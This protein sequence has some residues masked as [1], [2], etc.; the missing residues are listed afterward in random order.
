MY[1]LT[2]KSTETENLGWL[3]EPKETH[4][5]NLT[6]QRSADD[7]WLPQDEKSPKQVR[8]IV[9]VKNGELEKI[10]DIC[11]LELADS[12][13]YFHN[14]GQI[15]RVAFDPLLG[16]TYITR[17]TRAAITR[18]LDRR[19]SWRR[20]NKSPDSPAQEVVIDPPTKH[21]G[22]LHETESYPHLPHVI[23]I[24]RQ[25]FFRADNTLM[26]VTGYDAQT[27]YFG[28]YNKAEFSVPEKPS[29]QDALAA[30]SIIT[31]LLDEFAFA[32]PCDKVAAIA[33]IL[34]AATRISISTAPMVHVSA[35]QI[36]TGKSYLTSIIS[37]F[38]SD[39]NP[40]AIAFPTSDEECQKLL[41]A[42]LMRSPPTII[43]DNLTSD[44]L[45][46]KSL[47][48][49][50]TEESLTGRILGSS[51]VASVST[52]TL[53]L[54]SGNNVG[55]VKDMSRRCLTIKLDPKVEIPAT[56]NFANNPLELIR[57]NRG[58]YA[59]LALTIVRAWFVNDC[60]IT[61]CKPL[62]SYGEWTK[63][64]RQPLLWLGL[65]DPAERIFTQLTEDPD[66]EQLGRLLLA[67]QRV[68]MDSHTSI[69]EVIDK[70]GSMALG[71]DELREVIGEIA[72]ERGDLNRK[73]LGRW[74]ARHQGQIVDGL[75]FD[76]GPSASGVERW[77]VISVA[78]VSV[79][80]GVTEPSEIAD[81]LDTD[82]DDGV[83]F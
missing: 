24:A 55:P 72:L 30:L 57:S 1:Q 46:F 8:R 9:T 47:C 79:V 2:P 83:P 67:W 60:P 52:K 10:I 3:D 42:T 59:S 7:D 12:G 21:I 41:L 40:S 71:A 29:R 39:T 6:H 50:T 66:R 81:S 19:I 78:M 80:S 31:S 27:G 82:E 26:N 36:A 14:S 73:R 77:R 70:S 56:R 35:H 20:I 76:R 28:S 54:S 5:N 75:R 11:E 43:F 32:A 23:G 16:E 58:Y 65:T 44:I 48:S 15:V 61:K 4:E 69:R 68:F 62:S 51:K 22:L 17:V 63:Y 25:P 38:A 34:T 49:A 45:A 64:V 13:E 53:L 33:A 74:I 18:S 37:A